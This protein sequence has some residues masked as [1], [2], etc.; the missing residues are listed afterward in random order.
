[1][2]DEQQK[3]PFGPPKPPNAAASKS[4]GWMS[5]MV[6]GDKSGF[7]KEA[8]RDIAD[9]RRSGEA[10]KVS[11]EALKADLAF[12][13]QTVDK[14]NKEGI[15]GH[16]GMINSFRGMFTGLS[17]S[18]S[19][20]FS[21]MGSLMLKPFSTLGSMIMKPFTA[22][23]ELFFKPFKIIKEKLSSI[24]GGIKGFG[25][26]LFK[27]IGSV[28][29]APFKMIGGLFA[30]FGQ[31]KRQAELVEKIDELKTEIIEQGGVLN[32]TIREAHGMQ[33]PGYL[34]DMS[35]KIKE[36]S[37]KL[38]GTGEQ[39]GSSEGEQLDL[40]GDKQA[41]QREKRQDV[42][43]EKREKKQTGFLKQIASGF[44]EEP[45]ELGAKPATGATGGG[46]G[47]AGKLG[48][49]LKG[50]GGAIGGALGSVL[51]AFIAAFA[52][53]AII[54]G[55]LVLAVALPALGLA[56]G[57]FVATLGMAAK[58]GFDALAEAF[59]PFANSIKSF[60]E[61][62]GDRL[63][64]TGLGMT[65]LAAGMAAFGAGTAVAGLG[66][67]V[68]GI[69]EGIVGLFGGDDPLEK[70]LKFQ[71]YNFDA[72]RIKNNADAMI[73]YSGAMAAAGAGSAVSGLGSLVGGIASGIVGLFGGDTPLDKMLEFQEYEFDAVRIKNN[74][75]AMVAYGGAMASMGAGQ[76]AEGLGSLVGGIASGIVGLFGGKDD[77]LD[78]MLKFQ[79]YKF[80]V[81]K[82]K[83]NADAIQQL[84]KATAN[85]GKPSEGLKDL[86]SGLE[87]FADYLDD[88]E[89]DT[90]DKAA[91]AIS[92][93]RE[94]IG[95]KV[96]VASWT[97]ASAQSPSVTA[98]GGDPSERAALAL[99][100]QNRL[101]IESEGIKS[102]GYFFEMVNLLKDIAAPIKKGVA[103]T[104]L[105]VALGIGVPA[106]AAAGDVPAKKIS[107]PAPT[108]PQK[109]DAQRLKRSMG[110]SKDLTSMDLQD[111][112]LD[113]LKQDE[114]FRSGVYE[115]T[116]GIKTVGYGF[117]LERAGAQEALDA[118]GIKKSLADL[119][120]GTVEITEEEADRL[121]RGEYPHFADAAKR[122]VGEETWNKL[123]LDRQKVLTNMVYNMGEKTIN[124]F[125]NLRK[126][127]QDGDWEEAGAQMLDSA[128]AK[129]VK[130]R[131]TR[132]IKRMTGTDTP[133]AI[134][135]KQSLTD[136]KELVDAETEMS[137]A[138]SQ[139]TGASPV[140]VN[141]TVANS[142]GGDTHM[143]V[144]Q[145]TR[146]T[147]ANLPNNNVLQPG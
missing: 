67:L 145:T 138:K 128:W 101:K 82:I 31:K 33:S 125:S 141:N 132:L 100:E 2:A 46:G 36:L 65:A 44:E 87:E 30:G 13:K 74:A 144:P 134:P 88:G 79:E 8:V 140:I 19:G 5:R 35:K 70:M 71:E 133:D 137:D 25:G 111:I 15:P 37:E 7:P 129:Q 97:P 68:G 135:T 131:S 12:I 47:I 114:G 42:K 23:K 17:S 122:Y 66:S 51:A 119:K 136:A 54:A 40:F 58:F 121:M 139:A 52:N 4:P 64:Q 45:S 56:L 104:G 98:T 78:K 69:T 6:G 22:M 18:I 55:A 3:L 29:S 9:T 43:E 14:W 60:E 32:Q 83:N 41:A 102:P 130:G 109:L 59:P 146:N 28:L 16:K 112:N 48:G 120:S 1:M 75:D 93:L 84:A 10:V 117:N 27:G 96:T 34:S 127:I 85:I 24:W 115:D 90:I 118:A 142:T 95:K 94:V 103:A 105:G 108:K 86:G 99:E 11:T 38:L 123:S 126:A 61:L 72:V 116:M 57:G 113:Q 53:P 110:V 143:I 89:I 124:K 50:I 76:A 77:P 26:K 62:D 73:A 21:T 39:K 106:T 147:S 49:A 63:I 20:A 80:D 81:A 92:K 91:G 107:I